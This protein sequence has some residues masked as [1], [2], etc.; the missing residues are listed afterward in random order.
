MFPFEAAM[1]SM[2]QCHKTDPIIQ[3]HYSFMLTYLKFPRRRP[4]C[5]I[6]YV[7]IVCFLLF[8]YYYY[9]FSVLVNLFHFK[10]F[11]NKNMIKQ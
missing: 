9:Y 6:F 8:F 1:N 11:N 7:L 10:Y 5:T 4:I 2:L 3:S